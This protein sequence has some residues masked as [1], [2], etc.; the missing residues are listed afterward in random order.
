MKSLVVITFVFAFHTLVLAQKDKSYSAVAHLAGSEAVSLTKKFDFLKSISINLIVGNTIDPSN[1]N[2][3]LRFSEKE[4]YMA[5][6]ISGLGDDEVESVPEIVLDFDEDSRITFMCFGDIKM[7]RACLLDDEQKD[8]SIFTLNPVI[9]KETGKSKN[10]LGY[11]S[12]E[13]IISDG[14]YKGSIWITPTVEESLK[15][16]FIDLGLKHEGAGSISPSGYIMRVDV[17][18]AVTKDVVRL[19]VSDINI[20]DIYSIDARTYVSTAFPSH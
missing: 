19:S 6:S 4:S 3:T 12:M 14:D 7:A 10:I 13:Y 16:P 1:L 5:M 18:N 15:R 2:Y 11:K 9:H 17:D 8:I 20:N